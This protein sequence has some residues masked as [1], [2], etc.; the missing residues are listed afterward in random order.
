MKVILYIQK[1]VA[2]FHFMKFI[3]LG[4]SVNLNVI[5]FT[6]NHPVP[7]VKHSVKIVNLGKAPLVILIKIRKIIYGLKNHLV[8]V[9]TFIFY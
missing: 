2:T 6:V 4:N 3:F 5:S 8:S 1:T 9:C 7:V